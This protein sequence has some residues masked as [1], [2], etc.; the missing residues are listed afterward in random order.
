MVGI[1]IVSHSWKISEGI[2]DLAREMARENEKIISA[3]GLD[4]GSIGTDALKILD[5]IKQADSGDGVI[6]LADL[7]SGI[8]SAETAIELLNEEQESN[9]K[10]IN[11][12]LAD[13]PIVEGAICAAVESVSG[14]N[15]KSVLN[16]AEEIRY[17]KKIER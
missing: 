3:G 5:A 17:N 9:S 10:K 7:G 14:G 11:V 8:M 4:D 6:I 16:A 15:L 2:C 13:A 1:V 12:L